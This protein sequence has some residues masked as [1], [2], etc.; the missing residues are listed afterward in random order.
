MF[1]DGNLFTEKNEVPELIKKYFGENSVPVESWN[2]KT[3]K[4]YT[5]DALRDLLK[6]IYNGNAYYQEAI[7][8]AGID[9]M[10]FSE[11]KDFR[12]LGFLEKGDLQK[13]TH[14]ILSVGIEKIVQYFLSTGTSKGKHIYMMH[15]LDDLYMLDLAPDMK[16]LLPVNSDDVV[17]NALP[18]EMSSSGL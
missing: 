3:I 7:K 4:E 6:H 5:I 2:P 17:I 15:T 1:F 12:K 10:N 18:Y 14:L 11:L 8:K 9:P 13:D 16:S